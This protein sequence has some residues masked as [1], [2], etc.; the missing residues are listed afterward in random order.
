MIDPIRPAIVDRL[1]SRGIPD[2]VTVECVTIGESAVLVELAGV[3]AADR[4]DP[5]LA[6]AGEGTR[7][8]GLAHR[9]PGES[10]STDDVDLE[11]LLRWATLEFDDL[12]GESDYDGSEADESGRIDATVDGDTAL[13]IALGV[14]AIN[15]LSAPSIDWRTGD[16]MAL[17]DPSVDVIA[18]VG[19]FK[20]AFRKFS[21]VDVRVIERGD[22]GPVSAPDDVRVT[23]FRPAEATAAMAD[24]DVVFVTGS[25]FVY[26]GLE[27]YLEAAPA[28]A[29]V[30]L[31]GATASG[32]PEPMFEAGVDVVAGAEVAA[33][34]RVREAVQSG[35]C[36]T[37]LHDAGVRKVYTMADG[38]ADPDR[39]L[40]R[41]ATPD[42]RIN[43]S[44]GASDTTDG[45]ERRS[46]TTGGS[47]TT[48]PSD[49][50]Q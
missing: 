34:D 44:E 6:A 47:E 26:G 3:R 29:T 40:R 41:P 10:V 11:T 15:A 35:A 17:L 20:P 45:S 5:E 31:I 37:D 49:S 18:T 4:S 8:A 50:N 27:R 46:E 13:R 32:L 38:V 14:A 33:P 36:G 9:P 12:G 25:V 1:R 24:A 7:T 23:T 43:R 19:A 42:E 48:D 22:V 16:P 39:G 30:V 28:D 21:D 2:G